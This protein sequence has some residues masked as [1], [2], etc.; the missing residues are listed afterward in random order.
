MNIKLFLLAS[1]VS[2]SSFSQISVSA[3]KIMKDVQNGKDITYK[4]VTIT[5]NLDFTFR[6]AKES[7]LGSHRWWHGTNTVNEEIEIAVSFVNCMFEG[8]VLAYIHVDRS[9]YTFTADFEKEVIFRD[10]TFDG[11][12]MFKYSEFDEEVDFSGSKFNRKNTFKYAEFDRKT[13]F[14]NTYFD[15]DAIFKYAEFND[16]VSFNSSEFMESLD[17]KYLEVKGVFDID[18]MEV[19]DDID[20]KYTEINGNSFAKH[21]YKTRQN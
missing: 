15:N 13:D 21:L 4:N 17:I 20:A 11:D 14:S 1:L 2:F 6:E 19:G 18:R 5:G 8:D 10:C 9:G 7:E 3:F 12:A 16:G